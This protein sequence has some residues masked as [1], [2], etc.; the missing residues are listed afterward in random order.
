VSNEEKEP[1][2]E[3]TRGPDPIKKI[4]R[5][6]LLGLVVYVGFYIFADRKT[7]YTDQGRVQALVTPIVPRVAGHLTQIDVRLH[8]V[9]DEGDPMFVIDKRPYE[10]AVLQAEANLDLVGQQVGSQMATVKSATARLGVAR[11]QLDRAQRNYARTKTILDNNPGALS[12]A[13]KDRAETGLDQAIERVSSAEADLERAR[14]QLGVEGPQNAQLRVALATLEQAQLDLAFTEI[15][16]PDRGI[17]ESFNVYRG[18][19]P[20]GIRPRRGARTHLQGSGT[21]RGAGSKH[22]WSHQPR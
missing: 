19:R 10:V 4:T 7:P 17:I 22:D 9:V 1:A 15:F 12:Q 18:R 8:S 2:A 21:Q 5:I 11:A 20:G 14:E 3:E 16:A 6:V 13:D